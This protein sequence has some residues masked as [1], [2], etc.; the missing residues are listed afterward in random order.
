MK[1]LKNKITKILNSKNI[2]DADFYFCDAE[3]IGENDFRA[4]TEA[5]ESESQIFCVS[6]IFNDSIHELGIDENFEENLATI[7]N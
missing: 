2:F 5:K 1:T 6:F 7:I 3:K 4:Q